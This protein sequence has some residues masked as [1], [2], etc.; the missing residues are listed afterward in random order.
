MTETLAWREMRI[1]AAGD[2]ALLVELGAVT[3]SELHA[4][5]HAVKQLPGVQ[6][7]TPGHSSLYVVF[8]DRPDTKTVEQA[9]TTSNQQPAT[10]NEKHTFTVSFKDEYA[11]D[12]GEFL[13]HVQL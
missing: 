8:N 4:K 2:K 12:L 7:C 3:A 11:A 13:R 1:V 5:S 6:R 10:R 9:L